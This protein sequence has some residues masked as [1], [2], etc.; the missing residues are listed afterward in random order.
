MGEFYNQIPVEVQSHLKD[1]IQSSGLPNSDESLEMMSEAW[2]EKKN[3]FEREIESIGMEEIDFLEKDDSRGALIMTYS[4]SLINIGPVSDGKRKAQYSSIGLRGD[5][6]DMAENDE[7]KLHSDITLD[8]VIEF[9]RG[10]V[11][12]TSAVFKIAV[13]KDML[14]AEEQEETISNATLI[15]TREFTDINKTLIGDE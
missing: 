3:A 12:S 8:D 13:C 7:S 14:D 1:I 6:P 9:E 4:G 5:V 10:P 2:I 15:L 11:R